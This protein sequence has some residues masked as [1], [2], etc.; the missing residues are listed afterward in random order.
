MPTYCTNCGSPISGAFCA[1]CGQQAKVS[2]APPP[3]D[4]TPPPPVVAAPQRSGSG[5]PLLIAGGILLVLFVVGLAGTVY[6]F[7]WFKNKA[8][9]KVSSYTGGM[10]G[11]PAEVRVANGNAC[12]MLPRE[13][14]QQVLGVT[15]EK[16]AEIMEGSDPGCAYFT[17]PAGFE[18]LRNLA[19]EQNQPASKSDNPLALLKDVNQLEGVV[20]SL[21]LT[22]A[23]K[24]GRVF[25][26]NVERGFGRSNWST[27]RAT[28]AVVP[29]FQEV[30]GVG[31]RAM[32]GSFG[33]VLY[34]LKGDSKITLE[35]INVPDARTRGA[36][37]GRKIAAHL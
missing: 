5:K 15:I 7:Y 28:M 1:N 22:E 36:D 17:N 12:S 27:L 25:A 32:V 23:D 9:A 31:D 14:L 34:V 10:V 19:L 30:Q 18:Q 13:D 26:F 6:G 4:A 2:T 16:T 3:P 37:I 29:G 24:E 21:G 20:K 35:L 11:S 8:M 33:H